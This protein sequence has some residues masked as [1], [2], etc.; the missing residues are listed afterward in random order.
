MSEDFKSI[1]KE[2]QKKPELNES[3]IQMVWLIF[4]E[5]L[6]R[7]PVGGMDCHKCVMDAFNKCVQLAHEN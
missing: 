1:I 4:S 5:T 6:K 7:P 2:M 3:D